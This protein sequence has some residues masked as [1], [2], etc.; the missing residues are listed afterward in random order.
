[1]ER[2]IFKNILF[3]PDLLIQQL[4]PVDASFEIKKYKTWVLSNLIPGN[5]NA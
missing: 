2:K 4:T 3:H 5:S 1:M